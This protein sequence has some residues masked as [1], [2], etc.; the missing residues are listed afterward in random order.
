MSCRG[1]HPQHPQ[2]TALLLPY[3]T[4]PPS[5]T[6]KKPNEIDLMQVLGSH[7]AGNLHYGSAINTNEISSMLASTG[8]ESF[9]REKEKKK[10]IFLAP[11]S[12]T[13]AASPPKGSTTASVPTP[14]PAHF[15]ITDDLHTWAAGHV[16]GLDLEAQRDTWL[17]YCRER[18]YTF[19]NWTRAFKGWLRE[20]HRRA[21]ASGHRPAPP[22][23]PI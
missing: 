7:S 17:A 23:P 13:P 8:A 12:Q 16:P 9:L 10:K 5:V 18:D 6:G 11:A 14:P 3:D 15:P 20:A 4:P 22:A 21:Q 19:P 2:Q 1:L